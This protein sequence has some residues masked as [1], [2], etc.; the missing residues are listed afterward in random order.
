MRRTGRTL[1]ND[2]AQYARGVLAAKVGSVTPTDDEAG[3]TGL[4]VDVDGRPLAIELKPMA[5]ATPERITSLQ[6][7]KSTDALVCVVADRINAPARGL[8]ESFGWAHLDASTGQLFLH[9][10]GVRIDTTVPPLVRAGAHR[11][12]GIVGHSGRVLAYEILRRHYDRSPDP[13]RTSTAS[14]EFGLARS[15]TSDAMRALRSADLIGHDQAP[16]L[17]ALFWELARVWQP[18][19]RHWLATAPNPD[20]RSDMPLSASGLWRLGGLEA[21]I[22]HGAP[23]VGGDEGLVGLYVPD[24]TQRSIAVRHYGAADP[25]AAAASIAAPPVPQLTA[26]TPDEHGTTRRGWHV[27]HP[28]AAALDLAAL[29]DARSHQILEEWTPDGEAVWHER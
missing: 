19:E 10:P 12:S 27:V 11:Q 21:A 20:D 9:A 15:S 1:A 3:A 18:A 17:P 2:L 25:I 13:I 5:Y 23:A 29:D 24:A 4:V 6:R 7:P 26:G 14:S 16:V 22:A 28:V 8:I